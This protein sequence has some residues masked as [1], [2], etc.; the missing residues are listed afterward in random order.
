MTPPLFVPFGG[1]QAQRPPGR[2]RA[3]VL[4]IA[5]ESG[6]SWGAGAL[7]GAAHILDASTQLED[8]DEDSL[9]RWDTLGVHTADILSPGPEPET[10]IPVIRRA[11]RAI[12][13]T[14]KPFLALGGDHAITIGL[15]QAA[16][17]R[18]P[19]LAVVQIDA[20]LDLRDTWNGSPYNHG[21]V[22]RRIAGDMGL[23]CLQIAPRAVSSE[24]LPVIE[25]LGLNPLWAKDIPPGT[26][27]IHAAVERLP[28]TV[29]LSLDA[30]GLD[31]SIM[32]A[33]G[34]PEPGGLTYRQAA[35]IIEILCKKRNLVAADITELAPM[36][37]LHHPQYTL[38]KLARKILVQG[39]L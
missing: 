6:P 37:N 20:H 39:L 38:A 29:Y 34:T 13:K 36:E 4:P 15:V 5:Y 14:G 23:P 22:M 9:I 21:C 30:D 25:R 1:W 2:A 24:E 3:V 8:M 33:T 32:P 28:E 10:A 31:P 26:D 16:A 19:G 7:H 35:D 27:W 11:A 18:H 17:E 12:L